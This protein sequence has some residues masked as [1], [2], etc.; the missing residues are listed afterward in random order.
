[1]R[2][3][4]Q[5]FGGFDGC[6][7]FSNIKWMRQSVREMALIAKIGRYRLA[8]FLAQQQPGEPFFLFNDQI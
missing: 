1:Q 6:H 7:D 2:Y 8:P 3:L 4:N 5:F